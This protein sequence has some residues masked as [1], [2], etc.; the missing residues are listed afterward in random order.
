MNTSRLLET[1]DFLLKIENQMTLQS[2]LAHVHSALS[3]LSTQPTSAQYQTQVA[4]ALSGLKAAHKQVMESCTH[5]DM[6]EFE[7]LGALPFFLEDI[8]NIIQKQ[9]SENVA[10][11]AVSAQFANDKLVARQKYIETITQLVENLK[12]L[13]MKT[14]EIEAGTTEVC[15]TIPWKLFDSNFEGLLGEL[16][17]IHRMIRAL[18]EV[19]TGSVERIFVRQISTSDPL[20]SFG[21]CVATAIAFGKMV[22]WALDTWKNVEDIRALREQTKQLKSGREKREPI[23]TSFDEMIRGTIN[24]AINKKSEEMISSMRSA[25]SEERKR[26]LSIHLEMV[27]NSALARIE[28]GMTIEIRFAPVDNGSEG[29]TDDAMLAK[30]RHEFSELEELGRKLKFPSPSSDPILALPSKTLLSDE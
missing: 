24:D 16:R 1:L 17:E 5:S 3:A 22:D 19:S 12:F 29:E 28:R 21:L 18:S 25:V 30:Q 14:P 8:A 4:S 11:P 13:G 10:T 9:V 15:F 27:L 6:K 20:F 26:E 23:I 7:E 2:R